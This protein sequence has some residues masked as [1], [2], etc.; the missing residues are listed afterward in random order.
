MG[1]SRVRDGDGWNVVA[2]G[3]LRLLQWGRRVFA[4]ET[5]PTLYAGV[6][7]RSRFNGAVACS[8]RRHEPLQSNIAG[9]GSLQWGRRVFATETGAGAARCHTGRDA[10]MGP[11]RVRDGDDLAHCIR[12]PRV[13]ASMGP[14]RVRDGDPG[15]AVHV[16]HVLLLQWGRR[17]FATETAE[18]AA[19]GSKEQVLQWG[20]RVFATE[21]FRSFRGRAGA[22]SRFNG[23]VACSRRRPRWEV[24][25]S[26][27]R[28]RFNGAVA[29]SRRR[30]VH[31]A[32]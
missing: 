8:R 6:R 7:F 30:P 27:C 25:R 11:S 16:A 3:A 14:S 5:I 18:A 31:G 4:T 19:T 26:G 9:A 29:C 21:T 15:D 23:A 2:I 13:P 24:A 20:R 28:D 32:R 17:V 12:S 22:R 1:P 10:S